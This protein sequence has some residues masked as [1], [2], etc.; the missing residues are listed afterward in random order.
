MLDNDLLQN[1]PDDYWNK[2]FDNDTSEWTH[3]YVG[4]KIIITNP[5]YDS[6]YN[7]EQTIIRAYERSDGVYIRC[8]HC[9]TGT[10][11]L[12]PNEYRLRKDC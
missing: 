12:K 7:T 3:S 11:T 1:L 10:I 2:T 9:K 8:Q 5:A 6:L 4:R